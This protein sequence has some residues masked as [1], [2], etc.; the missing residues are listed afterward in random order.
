MMKEDTGNNAVYLAWQA[1]DTRR[2]H[3]V[4]LLKQHEQRY[5]FN[6][7]Q[8]A[9]TSDKFV[10][11]IGMSDLQTV[12]YSQALF[13]LFG[14]RILSPKRP[15][16]PCFVK[17]LGLTEQASPFEILSRSGGA[18]TTDNLQ[19]FKP[20]IPA[21]DGM[22]EYYFF[23]HGLRHLPQS[24]ADR[25]SQLKAGDVL[26]LQRDYDNKYDGCATLVCATNPQEN[27]GFCPA[28]IT[29]DIVNLLEQ[30]DTNLQLMVE[31]LCEDAPYQYR[32]LCKLQGQVDI[33]LRG[34]LMS[35][36]EFRPVVD[37]ADSC[38]SGV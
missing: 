38:N 21:Q 20:L 13:P 26:S 7:T 8:G 34:K 4:G 32:L 24:A 29:E 19:V 5:V 30:K 25:V 35:T 14:N 31:K 2:W 23:A 3:V 9:F 17:W 18:R 1:P 16:F 12:Y 10:P 28:Y 11:F 36:D 37:N 27:V 15:E 6:Y 22:L 33:A